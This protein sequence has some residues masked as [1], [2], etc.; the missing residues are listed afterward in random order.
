MARLFIDRAKYRRLILKRKL[1]RTR[2]RQDQLCVS[3]IP[4]WTSG[5]PP[6]EVDFSIDDR[7]AHRR[8]LKHEIERLR[9]EQM[10][11]DT[12][13]MLSLKLLKQ[14]YERDSA[15]VRSELR[16]T[17]AQ[18][19]AI[20]GI[21][22]LPEEL[23]SHIFCLVTEQPKFRGGPTHEYLHTLRL[24]CRHWREV[25]ARTPRLWST[26]SISTPT[27]Y[28]SQPEPIA[29]FYW[30]SLLNRLRMLALSRPCHW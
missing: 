17:S 22:T 28:S 24:V 23:L 19:H 27:R 8:E 26:L 29:K 4:P 2:L 10:R 18:L 1:Q 6:L 7:H 12:G 16:T 15:A 9:L 20:T 13:Y 11:L 5:R 3:R 30:D 14:Q 21:Q 25:C